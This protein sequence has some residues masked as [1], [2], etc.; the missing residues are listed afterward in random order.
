MSSEPRI[1]KAGVPV[2]FHHNERVW[3]ETAK[4]ACTIE[5]PSSGH[6]YCAV[7]MQPVDPNWETEPHKGWRDNCI[8]VWICHH[9]GPEVP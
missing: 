2:P 9:H 4:P 1:I 7:H 5:P 8:A 6:W 3:T